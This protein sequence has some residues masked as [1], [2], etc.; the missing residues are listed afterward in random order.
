MQDFDFVDVAGFVRPGDD[1]SFV[2]DAVFLIVS[3]FWVFFEELELYCQFLV[4]SFSIRQG[5]V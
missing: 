4:V 3:D 5:D 1:G 2:S